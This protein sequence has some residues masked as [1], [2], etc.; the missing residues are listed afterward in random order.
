MRPIS[1]MPV[2]SLQGVHHD[3]YTVENLDFTVNLPDHIKVSCTKAEQQD[4]LLHVAANEIARM[5]IQMD[6]VF[7]IDTQ[8]NIDTH[9]TLVGHR[10]KV[11]VIKK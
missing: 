6:G 9:D 3:E 1:A 5:I 4:Y 7:T 10:M 2:G 8:Y 11:L